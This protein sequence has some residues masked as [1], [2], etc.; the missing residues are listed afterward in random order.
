MRIS[1]W[2]R[3][4]RGAARPGLRGTPLL[5][6]LPGG[7]TAAWVRGF[8]DEA[9]NR[10]S[11]D[12]FFLSHVLRLRSRLPDSAGN[13][14]APWLGLWRSVAGGELI[15]PRF[16]RD[17]GPL[18]P[19]LHEQAI[20]VWT[21]GELC[22]VH[23]LSWLARNVPRGEARLRHAARWLIENIQPDNAT[24]HPWGVHV[25]AWL[26]QDDIEADMYAQTLLHNSMA[27]RS[28]PDVF[29]AA[30]LWDAADWLEASSEPPAGTGRA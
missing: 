28:E 22:G 24:A 29:S 11:V 12:P 3:L 6:E 8:R 20:E 1:D 17:S 23:A 10:R 15:Q 25:F 16:D 19:S 14:A 2:I 18:F 5:G 4:F 7:D 21:E 30:I 26:G 27:G 13:N 9:A